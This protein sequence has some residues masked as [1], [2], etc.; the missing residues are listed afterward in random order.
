MDLAAQFMEDHIDHV[1]KDVISRLK[2]EG[3][4]MD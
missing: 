3:N 2:D 4:I 1:M